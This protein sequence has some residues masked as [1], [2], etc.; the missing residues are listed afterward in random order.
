MSKPS[1]KAAIPAAIP[2]NIENIFL[3]H[4]R[5][6]GLSCGEKSTNTLN[7]Q[8]KIEE[9]GKVKY[10]FVF[11]FCAQKRPSATFRAQFAHSAIGQ[12]GF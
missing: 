11:A 4:S 5:T 3:L 7:S 6:T 10:S 2:V 1:T 9:K 8:K 12:A